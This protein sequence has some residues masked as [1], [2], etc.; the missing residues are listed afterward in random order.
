MIVSRLRSYQNYQNGAVCNQLTDVG[1]GEGEC[2]RIELNSGD[3]TGGGGR[4]VH[5]TVHS[6]ISKKH[7][8]KPVLEF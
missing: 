5:C 2:I 3:F 7:L 1:R 8:H 4:G 6:T